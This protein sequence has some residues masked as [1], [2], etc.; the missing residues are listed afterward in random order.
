MVVSAVVL[1]LSPPKALSRSPS[2]IRI[3]FIPTRACMCICPRL[4]VGLFHAWEANDSSLLNVLMPD[5]FPIA[6]QWIS[7]ILTASLTDRY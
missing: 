4:A 1:G 5:G 6:P 7:P 2:M 3:N